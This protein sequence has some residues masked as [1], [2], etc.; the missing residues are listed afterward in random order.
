[1]DISAYDKRGYLLEEFHLFHL[2]DTPTDEI[3]Y[4]YHEFH[5]LVLLISGKVA[6]MVEGRRYILKAGDIVLVGRGLIHRPEIESGTPYERV[7]IYISPDFLHSHSSEECSL[8]ACF[9]SEN[10]VLRPISITKNTA[11]ALIA[12]LE[13]AAATDA[14]GRGLLCRSLIIQLLIE[15][16]RGVPERKLSFVRTEAGDTKTMQILQ[17]INANLAEDISI[18]GLAERFY[19]SKYHMMRRFRAE[20]GRS[21]H[22]CI[23]EKRLLFAGALIKDGVSVTEACYRSGF[24]NYSTFSRAYKQFF[25]FSPGG[26]GSANAVPQG[27][28]YGD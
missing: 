2:H 18:S 23:S 20:T 15:A 12:S 19:I 14:F 16:A 7:V 8:D 11:A 17:Y 9:L 10:H 3:G 27:L 1:M 25:G 28:Q 22:G 21:I 5:K 13:S 26:R 6:Y 24:H 4:H